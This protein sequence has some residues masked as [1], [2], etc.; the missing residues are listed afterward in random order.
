MLQSAPHRDD[1]QAEERVWLL[2]TS[3]KLA[4]FAQQWPAVDFRSSSRIPVQPAKPK[5]AGQQANRREVS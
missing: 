1:S 4:T 2:A 5:T 3:K